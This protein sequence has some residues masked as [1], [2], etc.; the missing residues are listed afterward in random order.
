MARPIRIEYA[1]ASYHVIDRG[2]RRNQIFFN[3]TDYFI[4]LEKLE[5]YAVL[6]TSF[7]L[8][9]WGNNKEDKINN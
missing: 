3:N 2:N 7:I 5:K 6:Y 4:F 1:G 9:S 8:S